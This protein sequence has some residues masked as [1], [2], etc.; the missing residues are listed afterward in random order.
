[1]RLL[2]VLFASLLSQHATAAVFDCFTVVDPRGEVVYKSN[3]T[4]I[5]LSKNISE[6]MAA[7]YP[8]HHLIWL[9]TEDACVGVDRLPTRTAP[10]ASAQADTSTPDAGPRLKPRQKTAAARGGMTHSR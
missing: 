3:R 8:G 7:T 9:Q 10:S 1:M 4:P 6:A 5:D 2:C